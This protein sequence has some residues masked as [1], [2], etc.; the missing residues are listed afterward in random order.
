LRPLLSAGLVVM[1]TRNF[2]EIEVSNKDGLERG[3]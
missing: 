3:G 1:E 2:E